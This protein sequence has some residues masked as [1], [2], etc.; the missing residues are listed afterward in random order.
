MDNKTVPS[1][2]IQCT[3]GSQMQ[4]F[5]GDRTRAAASSPVMRRQTIRLVAICP[6]G[7]Q[8]EAFYSPSEDLPRSFYCQECNQYFDRQ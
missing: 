1:E 2:V 8:E 3:G 4:I 6:E 5:R 7:H